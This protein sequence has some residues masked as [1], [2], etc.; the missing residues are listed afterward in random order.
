MKYHI[1]E[2]NNRLALH[3]IFDTYESASRHLIETIPE[4]VRLGYFM[5]KTLKA[6]DFTII[7]AQDK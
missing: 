6:N 2:T 5:D 1:V 7:E 3:G 4:Y